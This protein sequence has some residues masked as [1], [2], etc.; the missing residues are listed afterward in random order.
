MKNTRENGITLIALIITIIVMLILVGVTV[1][2]AL[3]GGLFDTAKEAATKTQ[4]EADYETLQA[5]IIG[6]LNKDLIIP[7]ADTL[8]KNLPNEWNATK[9]GTIYVVTSSNKNEFKVNEYGEIINEAETPTQEWWELRPGEAEEFEKNGSQATNGNI[10]ANDS[11]MK[12]Y[13]AFYDPD[14]GEPIGTL[15]MRVEKDGLEKSYQCFVGDKVNYDEEIKRGQWYEIIN[16]SGA[17]K[18]Y[19]G[20]SPI[21][22]S[23][24]TNGTIAC[25]T[26]LERVIASFGN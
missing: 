9:E 23:D 5:G 12:T 17:Y 21:Q 8:Q 18:E 6:A 14:S 13:I 15:L 4:Y 20:P 24:F 25:Q 19:T 2:V 11:E 1:R 3:N 26:Y 10:I 22:V 7:D 16:N